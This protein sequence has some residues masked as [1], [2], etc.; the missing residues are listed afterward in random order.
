MTPTGLSRTDHRPYKNE[1]RSSRKRH[2]N[3]DQNDDEDDDRPEYKSKPKSTD[4]NGGGGYRYKAPN[5]P[6]PATPARK[7][8]TVIKR[9]AMVEVKLL[10]ALSRV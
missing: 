5:S 7:D 2:N 4:S 9:T 3:K 10:S 6:A 1:D 8:S